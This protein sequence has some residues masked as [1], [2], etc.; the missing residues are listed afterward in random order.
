MIEEANSD[1]P[2]G[3]MRL[4]ETVASNIRALLLSESPE[5]CDFIREYAVDFVIESI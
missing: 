2:L 4:I 3:K 5:S 1:V